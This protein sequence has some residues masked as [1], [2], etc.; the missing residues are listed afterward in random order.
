MSLGTAHAERFEPSSFEPQHGRLHR[1]AHALWALTDQAV[2]SGGNVLMAIVIG[3][4]LGAGAL[5]VY[6]LLFTATIFANSIMEATLS[7]SFMTRR[8]ELRGTEL[9][10]YNGAN[11]ALS[12]M[13]IVLLGLGVWAG[14]AAVAVGAAGHTGGLHVLLAGMVIAYLLREQSRRYEF[15]NLRMAAALRSDTLAYGLQ[16]LAIAVSLLV[17]RFNIATALFSMTLGH[18]T[19]CMLTLMRRRGEFR[20]HAVPLRRV[21]ADVFHLS[22]WVLAAHILFV[23]GLQMMP[24]LVVHELGS[25]AAGTYAA[26]MLL[27]N[28]ANPMLTGFL[29]AMMPVGAAAYPRGP[30]AIRQAL[31]Q[32]MALLTGLTAVICLVTAIFARDLLMLLFGSSYAASA[33]VV[34]TLA[35]SFFIRSLDCGPY[36]GCW[37]MRRADQNVIG[38]LVNIVLG[39]G[40]ALA[41]MPTYG[42]LGAAIGLLI[43]NAATVSLRWWNFLR[44][45]NHEGQKDRSPSPAAIADQEIL[46]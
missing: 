15:A 32:N 31:A 28:M 2:V 12:G 45:L 37:A 18:G 39:A 43:A 21:L 40:L 9:R 20:W 35:A 25:A 44:L 26:A 42:V 14:S 19:A 7:S 3:R 13:L 4:T 34:Q 22:R 17:T 1:A 27:S 24:W 33:P 38:N 36:V 10:G 30:R 6:T 41:L 29:N 16:S 5:G 46:P 8:C 23:I 11:M